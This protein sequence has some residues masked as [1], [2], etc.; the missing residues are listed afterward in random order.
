MK[1]KSYQIVKK[2]CKST[3]VK[4]LPR[5]YSNKEDA[6]NHAKILNGKRTQYFNRY[7]VVTKNIEII[8]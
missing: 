4:V 3:K 5:L 7:E 2:H 6:Q 8:F 1:I